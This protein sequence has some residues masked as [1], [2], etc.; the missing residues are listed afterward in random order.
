MQTTLRSTL[1]WCAMFAFPRRR[2]MTR[3]FSSLPQRI[4]RHAVLAVWGMTV[5]LLL[6]ASVGAANILS[7]WTELNA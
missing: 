7:A 5:L 2:G 4:P 1:R 3:F 6:T